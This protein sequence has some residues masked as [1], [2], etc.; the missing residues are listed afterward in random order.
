MANKLSFNLEKDFRYSHTNDFGSGYVHHLF[1][2][3]VFLF[4]LDTTNGNLNTVVPTMREEIATWEGE[5]YNITDE[6]YEVHV[7]DVKILNEQYLPQL[8]ERIDRI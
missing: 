2:A 8:Q 6:Q 1:S 3:G 7:N 4:W 5:E